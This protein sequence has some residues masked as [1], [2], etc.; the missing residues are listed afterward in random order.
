MDSTS[1]LGLSKI[2][3]DALVPVADLRSAI[4]TNANKL[5]TAA[6]I[7]SGAAADRPPAGVVDRFYW[8]DDTNVLSHD[9]GT[10]WES[11][12]DASLADD[13]IAFALI[14]G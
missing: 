7:I 11:A 10:T 13:A 14:L 4:N 1:R 2:E 8:A 12:S 3:A 6:L 9:N 5:D